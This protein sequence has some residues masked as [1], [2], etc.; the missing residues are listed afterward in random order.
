MQRSWMNQV[1]KRSAPWLVGLVAT[2][3]VGASALVVLVMR[4]RAPQQDVRELTVP[5]QAKTI[6][7]RIA[8]NGTVVPIRTVNLSPKA[9]GRL[10]ELRVEQGD[11]VQQGQIVARMESKEL[12]A[13][14]DQA[15]ASL[16]QARANLSLVQA[17]S[18]PEVI[19]QARATVD[20]SQAQVMEAQARLSLANQRAQ[21]NRALAAEGA[22]SRDRLDE[23]LNEERS[24]K[25]NLEQTQARLNNAIQQLSQQQNGSRSQEIEQAVAQVDNA[26][27]RLNALDTQLD[28]TLIRAPFSGI[29]TQK[30]ATEGA[31]VTPTTSASS[32]SSAT[33]TS[34]VALSTGL[35][36]LAKVP[37]V[38]VGA[39]K[40]GQSVEIKADAYANQVFQGKVRLIAPEAVLDQNV[41][42]FQVRVEITSGQEKLRSGMNTDVTFLGEQLEQTLIVPTVAIVTDK[43]QTGVLLL[44]RNNKPQ[45]QTVSIG[46]T[47]AN[48]TQILKGLKAGD[49]VFVELPEGQ[50][51]ETIIKG[52]DQKK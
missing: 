46:Q 51:L 33:S 16:N 50:K 7:L 6:T 23:V 17:G 49:L 30:Y 48:Q 3:L 20:Q 19:S 37:E 43:G 32:T 14:R 25:A 11:R 12:A 40:L 27:A 2:G 1:K 10:A 13:E 8:A 42:S 45:F 38:D 36:V 41:T 47:I 22:I 52:I 4:T 35:E 39:I 18:R 9:A 28:D 34:I 21:R 31:F 15:V 44:G 5:V 29:I 24:A 26:K